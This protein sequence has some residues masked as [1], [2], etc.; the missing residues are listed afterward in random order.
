MPEILEKEKKFCEM[1]SDAIEDETVAPLMY[2]ELNTLLK[3]RKE[4]TVQERL[5]GAIIES[6]TKDERKHKELLEILD[7]LFCS[8]LR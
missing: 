6:I 3:E 7:E 1:L 2:E 5:A 4:T 8:Y